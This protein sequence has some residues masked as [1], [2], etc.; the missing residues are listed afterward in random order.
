MAM[1][2]FSMSCG[3]VSFWGLQVNFKLPLPFHCSVWTPGEDHPSVFAHAF[4]GCQL[5]HCPTFHSP[6]PTSL[7]GFRFIHPLEFA[8]KSSFHESTTQSLCQVQTLLNQ[9]YRAGA[10]SLIV[11]PHQLMASELPA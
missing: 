10:T 7:K 6:L 9:D 1:E 5:A 3:A 8:P 11:A 2:V 4:A